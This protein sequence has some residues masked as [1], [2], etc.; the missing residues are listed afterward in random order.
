[1]DSV[2]ARLR[3]KNDEPKIV[4]LALDYY[5]AALRGQ[6]RKLSRLV[7]PRVSCNIV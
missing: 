7:S 1:M 5:R 6:V 2:C 3:P 4:G